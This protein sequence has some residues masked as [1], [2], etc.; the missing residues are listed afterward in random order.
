VQKPIT[1][2]YPRPPSPPFPPRPQQQQ[3]H[4]PPR[5]S[6]QREPTVITAPTKP[7]WEDDT[8][9][10]EEVE[11][12]FEAEEDPTVPRAEDLYKFKEEEE[13]EKAEEE[14]AVEWE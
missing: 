3:P 10:D 1:P 2:P 11:F 4:P 6:P 13:E 5:I 9:S 7:L 14:E 8:Y 12:E